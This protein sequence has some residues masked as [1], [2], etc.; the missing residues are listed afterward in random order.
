MKEVAGVDVTFEVADSAYKDINLADYPWMGE[1]AATLIRQGTAQFIGM[2]YYLTYTYDGRRVESDE[3]ELRD[4]GAL[5]TA[6]ADYYNNM[7]YPKI[8]SG[9][10]T[11]K[12]TDRFV[13]FIWSK[14]MEE[15]YRPVVDKMNAAMDSGDTHDIGRYTALIRNLK[16]W[17]MVKDSLTFKDTNG[18]ADMTE[19]NG[20]TLFDYM[21]YGMDYIKLVRRVLGTKAAATLI[22]PETGNITNYSNDNEIVQFNI[23][24]ELIELR[25]AQ[26]SS[27]LT[28]TGV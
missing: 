21:R 23:P 7:V 27:L 1:A 28:G 14:L 4:Q 25:V 18:I 10:L 11:D 26:N 8:V 20:N 24:N 2:K 5:Q 13:A 19:T 3:F 6:I 12:L 22:D 9:Q 17:D 16:T 15:V